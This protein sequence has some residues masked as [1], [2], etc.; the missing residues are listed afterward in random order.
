MPTTFHE[1]TDFKVR[2]YRVLPSS[3]M[4]HATRS[5]SRCRRSLRSPI[6]AANS[7]GA[8][9]MH[10]MQDHFASLATESVTRWQ[11]STAMD[12]QIQVLRHFDRLQA[13]KLRHVRVVHLRSCIEILF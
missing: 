8:R 2:E 10:C 12:V 3:A 6:R 5:R 11:L 7:C 4:G 1:I 13:S 9:G